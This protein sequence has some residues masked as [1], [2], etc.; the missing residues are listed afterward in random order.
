MVMM[1]ANLYASLHNSSRRLE[2]TWLLRGS[3]LISSTCSSPVTTVRFPLPGKRATPSG[4]MVT[5]VVSPFRLQRLVWQ[6]PVH[7]SPRLTR[8]GTAGTYLLSD[9]TVVSGSLGKTPIAR[10]E[11]ELMAGLAQLPSRHQESLRV[12]LESRPFS[13]VTL[14]W[15][16]SWSEMDGSNHLM[17]CRS[18]WLRRTRS[19]RALSI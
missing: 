5:T 14:T 12:T 2:P 15:T 8:P 1:H 4:V 18:S 6:L 3:A 7:H 17:N 16:H 13:G 9:K 10:G 11:M 19:G